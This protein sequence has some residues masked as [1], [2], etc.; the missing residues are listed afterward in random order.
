MNKWSDGS[1]EKPRFSIQLRPIEKRVPENLQAI[2][3]HALIIRAS[4]RWRWLLQGESSQ[5]FRKVPLD[6]HLIKLTKM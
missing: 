3:S 5:S 6:G 2:Y 1:W 4:V